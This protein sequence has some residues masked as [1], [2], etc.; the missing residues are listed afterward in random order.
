MQPVSAEGRPKRVKKPTEKFLAPL[1][2]S[3]EMLGCTLA[4]RTSDQMGRI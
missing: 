1:V 3:S 2:Q 4:L